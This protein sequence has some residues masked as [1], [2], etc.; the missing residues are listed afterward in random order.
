MMTHPRVYEGTLSGNVLTL[1]TEGPSFD[2]EGK[3]AKYRDV[4]E[5]IS[6][7]HRVLTS[8]ALGD[9]GKWQTFMTAHYHRKK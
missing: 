6:D 2:T 9:D 5:F 7:D 3:L 8:R 1:D 4:T